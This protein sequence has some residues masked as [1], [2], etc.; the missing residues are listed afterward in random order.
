M[1]ATTL[2]A[3]TLSNGKKEK[4]YKNQI[5][6]KMIYSNRIFQIVLYVRMLPKSWSY[7]LKKTT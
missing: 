7:S 1:D 5:G 6:D 3:N 4:N 2:L